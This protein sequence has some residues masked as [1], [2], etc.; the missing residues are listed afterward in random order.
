MTNISRKVLLVATCLALATGLEAC[1]QSNSNETAGKKI[2]RTTDNVA[3]RT[4]EAATKTAEVLDDTALTTKVKAAILAE[5]G[6]RT[7]QIGVETRD[8]VVTLSGT[9]DSPALKDR[10]KQIASSVAGVRDVV[11]NVLAKTA[12]KD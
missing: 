11:D 5:P 3:A 6:L 2:D 1:D 10:A 9:V 12:Q 4:S 7:L 8:A